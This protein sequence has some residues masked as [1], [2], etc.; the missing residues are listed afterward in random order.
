MLIYL[1]LSFTFLFLI[2]LFSVKSKIKKTIIVICLIII[3]SISFILQTNDL[4]SEDIVSQYIAIKDIISK[5]IDRHQYNNRKHTL[6][7]KAIT[8]N[9]SHNIVSK[10]IVS[11]D[12]VSKD[13]VSKDIASEDIASEDIAS[14][15]NYNIVSKGNNTVNNI[16]YI[17]LFLSM[18][19][20]MIS[21][22]FFHEFEKVRFEFKFKKMIRPLLISP[23]VFSSI[24]YI[25]NE[26]KEITL[27]LYLFSFQNGFFWQTILDNEQKNIS[28]GGSDS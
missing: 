4:F 6:S 10:D 17:Y 24:Y 2:I 18:I 21:H 25:S 5:D 22:Y 27:L 8:I 19:L 14:K 3:I 16:E 20:G 12:I 26:S 1:I 9:K 7:I 13:I 15:E 23:I 11:K 28:N